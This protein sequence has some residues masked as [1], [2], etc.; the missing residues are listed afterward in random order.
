MF[1]HNRRSA[2]P[3]SDLHRRDDIAKVA[4]HGASQRDQADGRFSVSIQ[5]VE[6]SFSTIPGTQADG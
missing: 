4:G 3:H 5:R 1:W 6:L 2:R